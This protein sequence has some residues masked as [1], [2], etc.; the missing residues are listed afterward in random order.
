MQAERLVVEGLKRMGWSEAELGARR[1]G[2]PRKVDLA[3]ELRS[4]TT[5]PLAWVAERLNMGTRGHLAWL[6]QQ[7][8]KSRSAA[9]ANQN[10]L[11]K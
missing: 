5:M 3:W 10:L 2:E 4:Q 9:P 8:G 11:R 6:L 7:Q 1:K